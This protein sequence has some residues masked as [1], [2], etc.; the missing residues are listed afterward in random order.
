MMSVIFLTSI[1]VA[2]LVYGKTPGRI[3]YFFIACYETGMAAGGAL[4]AF[5]Y[6]LAI[7][8]LCNSIAEAAGVEKCQANLFD[9]AILRERNFNFN[10][11]LLLWV[12]PISAGI[13]AVTFIAFAIDGWINFFKAL[14]AAYRS[15]NEI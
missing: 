4:F 13:T 2:Y 15:K 11:T 5:M 14:I 8:D 9:T 7:R 1:K 6:T 3:G 10:G 12:A